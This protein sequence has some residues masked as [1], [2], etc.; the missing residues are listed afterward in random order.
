MH[1]L[2]KRSLA[3]ITASA[4][5]QI[6]DAASSAIKSQLTARTLVDV[7]GPHGWG[8]AAVNTGRLTL[9]KKK[10]PQGIPWGTR[11][12]L[13]LVEGRVP[14]LL[15]Q[16]E[17]DNATRGCA[18]LDLQPLEEA[19]RSIAHFEE[20]AIYQGFPDG[21]ITGMLEGT[22]HKPIKLPAAVEEYAKA[23]GGGVEV[24]QQAGINGPYALVLGSKAYYPL[25]QS[26][27]QG[28]PPQRII[29]ELIGGPILWSPVLA[30]G[31]LLSQRGGDF[32]LTIGADFAIGYAAHDRE[33]VELYLTESFTFRAIEPAAAV[34]LKLPA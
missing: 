8:L 10:S 13:P 15:N 33:N 28:Y 27:K 17:L 23:V 11:E 3:P 4:W 5:A 14:V 34:E 19:A 26:A 31:V 20:A 2:L 32:E 25:M 7:S 29:R 16:M 21:G 30:G 24:L 9:A 22:P 12:V 6:D 1:D 18:D